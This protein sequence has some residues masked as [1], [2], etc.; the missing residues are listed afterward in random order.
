MFRSLFISAVI[1]LVLFIS[2]HLLFPLPDNIGYSTIIYDKRGETIHAFLS[3][4][5]K[6][7][8]KTHLDEISPLL[9]KTLI[10]KEDRYFYY[11]FGVNPFAIARAFINNTF[12]LKRTSGASTITMQVARALE[13]KPRTYGN[14]LIEILRAFQL[15]LKYSKNEILQLYCNVLPYGGNIEGVKAASLLYFKKDPDH[16]SLAEITALSIIPNRPNSLTPGK[17]NDRIIHHRNIWLRRLEKEKIFSHEE[18]VDALA[19]PFNIFRAEVPRLAPHVSHRLNRSG[20][21]TIHSSID[22]QIQTRVEKIVQ[23]YCR[24][25]HTKG[26]SNASIVVIDNSNNKVVAYLGSANFNDSSIHGQVDGADA[27]RQPGSTLKPLLYALCIDQGLMTPKKILTDVAVSYDGYAPENFNKQ[28]SGKVPMDRALELSLNVPA[29]KSLNALGLQKMTRTLMACD[30]RQVKK[31]NKKLGLSLVLGGCG[32]SL[33]ELTALFSSFAKDGNYIPPSFLTDEAAAPPR[34]VV[35]EA[36]SFMVTDILSKINRPDF[37]LNWQSTEHMPKISWKTGT[38]YGRRDA[39]SIGYNK[40][41]TVGVWAGNF[42]G[43]GAADLSG[44]EIATPLLFRVF[45]ML[46]YDAD[47]HWFRQPDECDIRT[48]CSETGLPPGEHCTNLISDYFIPG[49]SSLE[50]CAHLKE[51]FISADGRWIYCRQC[52]PET[53]YKKKLFQ[54]IPGDL[55]AWMDEEGIVLERVPPHFSGCEQVFTDNI[56]LILSPRAGSEYLLS[57]SE[58]EPLQLKCRA[59]NDVNTVFWYVDNKF[60]KASD[61]NSTVYFF[62]DAGPVKISC[63][64]DKGRNRDAWINVKKVDM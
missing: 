7:R 23:A 64:D 17:H 49:I 56:P 12:H 53:G 26:I 37:P 51:E 32:T 10:Q 31:D 3:P 40:R 29:V 55:R 34:R 1:T 35:S 15:E 8:M 2:L 39:W 41:F 9:R 18:I 25:I 50:V 13:R 27:I 59:G 54:A 5:D 63:T 43:D 36:A 20:M 16:L 52:M 38:S 28:F 42:S 46:E 11:H 45:N 58:S 14:K 30:F 48:V 24:T 33:L 21:E 19:E 47:A 44:A 57:K 60:Y 61:V 4:D 6:W 62:P 22:L